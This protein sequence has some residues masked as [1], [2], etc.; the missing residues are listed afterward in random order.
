MSTCDNENLIVSVDDFNQ[1]MNNYADT[2][3]DIKQKVLMLKSAQQIVEEYLGYEL[4]CGH[5]KERHI[6]IGQFVV[7]LDKMPITNV[8]SVRVDGREIN[9]FEHGMSSITLPF[10][11][12]NN[13]YVEIEYDTG[14]TQVPSLIKITILK[15]A[16]LMLTEASGNIGIVS[17]SFGDNTRTF[18]NYTNYSK[19][20]DPLSLYRI[21]R[22]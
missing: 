21:F 14:W 3:D 13:S 17:K 6:G 18:V 2:K 22:L 9:N 5:H 10:R 11:L 20:L 7:H 4:S 19:Q 15:I 1:Y 16:G 8:W 12:C